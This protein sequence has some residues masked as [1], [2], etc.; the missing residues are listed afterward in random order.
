MSPRPS[1]P[2]YR[3]KPVYATPEG[4]MVGSDHPG[5]KEKMFDSQREYRRWCVL[6]DRQKAG[7]ISGLRRQVSFLLRA[8]GGAVVCRYKADLVYVERGQRVVEDVKGKITAMYK[9]K[10]K[11]MKAQY[12]IEILE[13]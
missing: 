10:R 4:L 2:K 5:P 7:E 11:W 3:N 1:K 9:L 8:E 6:I 12:G 13:T